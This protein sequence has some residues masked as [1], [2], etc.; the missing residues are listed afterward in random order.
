M[1]DKRWLV[2]CIQTGKVVKTEFHK[3]SWWSHVK[4]EKCGKLMSSQRWASGMFR[5]S[6][7]QCG[8]DFMSLS[9]DGSDVQDGKDK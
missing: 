8:M 6:C 2:F 3:E 5:I 9:P 7:D 4:C 1:K